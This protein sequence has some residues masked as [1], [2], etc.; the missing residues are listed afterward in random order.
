[1]YFMPFFAFAMNLS[2]GIKSPL[3]EGIIFRGYA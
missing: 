2:L 1:M 3:I